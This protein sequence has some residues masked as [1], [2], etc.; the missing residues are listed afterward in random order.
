MYGK[1]ANISQAQASDER[2]PPK[3]EDL[4]PELKHMLQDPRTGPG[5]CKQ[6]PVYNDMVQNLVINHKANT[7]K[8]LSYLALAKPG[9]ANIQA[10]AEDHSYLAQPFTHYMVES[11]TALT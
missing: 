10:A 5:A 3:I 8:T 7:G 6:C 11:M 2:N 9:R 4:K 1:L